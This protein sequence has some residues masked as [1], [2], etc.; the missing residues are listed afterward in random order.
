MIKI[1]LIEDEAPL[2]S[3]VAEWLT[4]EDYEVIQAADGIAGVEAVFQHQP[5]LILCDIMMPRLDGYGVLLETNANPATVATP[6]IFMTARASHDDLREGMSSGADD[7]ITKPFT[8]QELLHAIQNQLEKRLA[9]EQY[10]QNQIEQVQQ[11]LANEQEKRLVKA[12]LVGMFS[13][14]FRNPLS[15]IWS[16]NSLLR[17]YADRLD[18]QRRLTH[19][20]RIDAS[21]RQLL[22][23]LDDM[24]VVT[25][26]E[27]GSLQFKPE[28][29]DIS[30][31]IR[32]IAEEFQ[33]INN[34]TCNIFYESHVTAIVMADSRL[35]RQIAS[36]IISNAVK[37]SPQGGEVR[38]IF[39]EHGSEYILT[40]QDHG[41]GIDKED[42]ENLFNAFQRGS[43]V[44]KISG[45]GLGLAIVKEAATI[46]GGS[47]HL[48]SE[49]GQ[50]TTIT[51]TIVATLVDPDRMTTS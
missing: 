21:V 32:T 50:G 8:R 15:T 30:Q 35:I 51:A 14:D 46:H 34:E 37:Y 27:A 25:Q 38:V 1:L 13:H 22:Q 48:E 31:T 3:E 33:A 24:L 42:Q 11:A 9:R 10:H 43:N 26:M 29:I 6:F 39:K 17:D 2:R 41:I 20:N 5:D 18:E 7:Y 19:L 45:T 36:N 40:V 28:P 12:K 44:G 49:L 16:S 4:F 47:V 23:M